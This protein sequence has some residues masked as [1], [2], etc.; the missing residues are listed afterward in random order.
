MMGG[1]T[2]WRRRRSSRGDKGEGEGE[3]RDGINI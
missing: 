3:G 2:V 1:N